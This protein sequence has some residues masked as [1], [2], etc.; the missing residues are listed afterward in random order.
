MPRTYVDNK[1]NRQLGRVGMPVGSAVHSSSSSGYQSNSSSSQRTYVDNSM[2]RQLGRVGLELGT[3]VHSRSETPRSYVDNTVNRQLG[4]VGM[5]YGAAA[6]SNS[7]S[8]HRTYVDNSMN[9]Q[10]GRVGLELGTAVHSRDSK[11]PPRRRLSFSLSTNTPKTYVDNAVNQELGR[12]GMAHGTAVHSK[13][14]PAKTYVDNA[15]NRGLGRV[16]MAHGTAVHSNSLKIFPRVDSDKGVYVDNPFNRKHNRVGLPKGSVPIS[17]K[18]EFSTQG[19]QAKKVYVDNAFNRR[20]NRVGL[21]LGSRPI[22]RKPEVYGDTVINRKL[23]RVGKP[24]GATATKP[25]KLAALYKHLQEHSDE[26]IPEEFECMSDDN[27]SYVLEFRQ[28]EDAVRTLLEETPSISWQPQERASTETVQRYQGKIIDYEKLNIGDLIGHG[29][30]GD[31]FIATLENGE[32]VAVKKL[33]SQQLTKK[34]IQLFKNEMDLF[35]HLDHPNIV[36]FVGACIEVPNL[37]IIME[38][39]D[40]SLYDALHI[41]EVEFTDNNKLDI[42]SGVTNGLAYLHSQNIAH[43]DLKSKNV[44][45]INVPGVDLTDPSKPVRAKITDFGL[46]KIKSDVETSNSFSAPNIGTPLYSAPEIHQGQLLS[47]EGLKK[48]DIFSLGLLIWELALK[49]QVGEKG[50]TPVSSSNLKLDGKLQGALSLCWNMNPEKRPS[51]ESMAMIAST[52]TNVLE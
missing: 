44:L 41:K 39:M 22:S 9:R 34:R 29:G 2:N 4:G 28:R 37:A 5:A 27:F 11:L 31:V 48:A 49:V 43:C 21:P 45:L 51:A 10:L 7:S 30:F 26:E 42:T 12:V 3:A 24:W 50:L 36:S 52:F 14:Q 40:M 38:Y 47:L 35:L 32:V 20:H 8:S 23:D 46:S 33:K 25:N 18:N 19:T 6:N 1:M 13:S 15:M 16:G 17:R